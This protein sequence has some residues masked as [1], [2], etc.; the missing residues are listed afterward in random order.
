MK[1]LNSV[2]HHRNGGLEQGIME[3]VQNTQG[4]TVADAARLLELQSLPQNRT[5]TRKTYSHMEKKDIGVA[6]KIRFAKYLNTLGYK[7]IEGT[8]MEGRSGVSAQVHQSGKPDAANFS[9]VQKVTPIKWWV[10]L[11]VQDY[12]NTEITEGKF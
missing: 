11:A 3:A 10:R 2:T 6:A 5:E 7:V 9:E 8:I 1:Q 12:D 4:L